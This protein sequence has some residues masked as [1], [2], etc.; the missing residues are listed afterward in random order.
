MFSVQSGLFMDGIIALDIFEGSVTK[1]KFIGF[2][3]EQ[4]VNN[5]NKEGS[6][7]MLIPSMGST[8]HPISR[9][10]KCNCIG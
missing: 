1:E 6:S 10:T 7:H 2:I 3:Q 8:D 5:K 9:P 4:L